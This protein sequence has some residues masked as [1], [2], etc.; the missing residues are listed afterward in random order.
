MAGTPSR[1]SGVED[2]SGKPDKKD[3]VGEEPSNRKELSRS[4]NRPMVL[5]SVPARSNKRVGDGGERPPDNGYRDAK[6]NS[7]HQL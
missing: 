3:P 2:M 5:S 7:Q 6:G 4:V 1:F